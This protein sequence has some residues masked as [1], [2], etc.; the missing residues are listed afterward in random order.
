MTTRVRP[1]AEMMDFMGST[2]EP[3]LITKAKAKTPSPLHSDVLKAFDSYNE[4]L[5]N[6]VRG[7][8]P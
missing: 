1:G 5:Q 4:G 2:G 7:G 6:V 8:L 3:A